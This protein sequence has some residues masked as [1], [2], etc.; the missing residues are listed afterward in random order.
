MAEYHEDIQAK[1]PVPSQ[2]RRVCFRLDCEPHRGNLLWWLGSASL[3]LGILALLPCCGWLPGL[4]GIPLG[5]CTRYMAKGDLMKIRAG[6]MDPAGEKTTTSAMIFSN[7][8]LVFSLLGTVLWGG[9]LLFFG[10]LESP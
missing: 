3:C 6:R 2:E 1:R 9:G 5:L 10:W 8:G 7:N 4:V